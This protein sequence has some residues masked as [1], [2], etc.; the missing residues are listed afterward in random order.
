MANYDQEKEFKEALETAISNHTIISDDLMYRLTPEQMTMVPDENAPAYIL[1]QRTVDRMNKKF[2]DARLTEITPEEKKSFLSDLNPN[3]QLTACLHLD[4]IQSP[5]TPISDKLSKKL[6]ALIKMSNQ[7]IPQ[8]ASTVSQI[9]SLEKT[10]ELNLELPKLRMSVDDMKF[11]LNLFIGLTIP[12]IMF[13]LAM[14]WTQQLINTQFSIL[15][16]FIQ[17]LVLNKLIPNIEGQRNYVPPL[18]LEISPEF[19][20]LRE[21]KIRGNY[22][23]D[24]F[25]IDKLIKTFGN[26]RMN[27]LQPP[28]VV[29]VKCSNFTT[30][31]HMDKVNG[32]LEL[33]ENEFKTPR[34]VMG[35]E[36]VGCEPADLEKYV[37][38][39]E[40]SINPK[41]VPFSQSDMDGGSG[42]I[43]G[44]KLITDLTNIIKKIENNGVQNKL[45]AKITGSSIYL[46]IGFNLS[47]TKFWRDNTGKLLD[48]IIILGYFMKKF[49][50]EIKNCI[51]RPWTEHDSVETVFGCTVIMSPDLI[52]ALLM[53][54][55]FTGLSPMLM[56]LIMRI[57]KQNTEI[58]WNVIS[59]GRRKTRK[60]KINRRRNGRAG[61]KSIKGRTGRKSIK[62][63]KSMKKYRRHMVSRIKKT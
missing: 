10:T 58:G 63:R 22:N 19:I 45:T 7:I 2:K 53:Y 48:N 51:G 43:G 17:Q 11:I 3:A 57:L 21:K 23:A 55:L 27:K 1:A 4:N 26:W 39:F 33:L 12:D 15:S 49:M 29:T 20:A 5:T 34:G 31:E 38:Q 32:I 35:F 30:K 6:E 42:D 9:T 56:L 13:F 41:L 16:K 62:G 37:R 14:M 40:E 50:K 46:G 24:D 18:K 8:F 54:S 47:L 52:I 28:T 36:F 60:V 25:D 59:G 44:T 61:R